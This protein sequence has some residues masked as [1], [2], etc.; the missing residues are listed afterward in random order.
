L[1]VIG[2]ALLQSSVENMRVEQGMVIGPQGRISVSEIA[3]IW[4]RRPQDLPPGLDLGGLEV[5]AGYKAKRDSGTFSYAAHAVVVA[6]DPETGEVE[7]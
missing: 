5:T 3:R 4:Y 1:K 7:I 6:V 2:S